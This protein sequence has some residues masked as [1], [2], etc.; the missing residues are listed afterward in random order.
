MTTPMTHERFDEL[1]S[2]Y[3]EF[4]LDRTARAEMDA[5]AAGCERCG[6][7]LADLN[8]IREQAA[9][10]PDLAPS[11]DLWNGIA[12]RIA[13]PV[14]AI[15]PAAPR[16]GFTMDPRWLGVAAALLI[17]STAGITWAVTRNMSQPAPVVAV[18]PT[19]APSVAP[20]TVPSVDSTPKA[21]PQQY[22]TPF[23][24]RGTAGGHTRQDVATVRNT[25][26]RASTT[27]DKEIN[28]LRRIVDQNQMDPKTRA[29]LQH[30]LQIIDDAIAQ[31]RAA[32]AHDPNS[33]YL[34]KQLDSA[35]EQKLELLRTAALLPR[36]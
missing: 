12:D 33:D 5:H 22:A 9:Q 13:A 6:G 21:A 8:D 1:L 17:A 32:L 11:R 23:T 36:T 18:A 20:A 7:L 31:S 15:A 27:Y 4:S 26:E 3:L 19:A 29:I 34:V 35:L 28:A 24:P 25:G 16:R 14:V 2:D 30:N 10:L